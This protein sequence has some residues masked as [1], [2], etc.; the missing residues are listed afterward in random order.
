MLFVNFERKKSSNLLP[1]FRIIFQTKSRY[2]RADWN[3]IDFKYVSDLSS[4]SHQ[5]MC[6][7]SSILLKAKLFLVKMIYYSN[8]EV[9][10]NFWLSFVERTQKYVS[11]SQVVF[12]L[13]SFSLA[14]PQ[15]LNENE[16]PSWCNNWSQN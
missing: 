8:Y 9:L 5:K 13:L 14:D 6:T 3:F 2:A 12:S 1:F 4:K 11:Y 16:W 10:L 7:F 15:G